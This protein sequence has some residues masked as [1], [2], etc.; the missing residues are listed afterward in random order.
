MQAYQQA[1]VELNVLVDSNQ[2]NKKM[3]LNEKPLMTDPYLMA[4]QSSLTTPYCRKKLDFGEEK[5]K[6]MKTPTASGYMDAHYDQSVAFGSKKSLP[7]CVS[8]SKRNARERKRVRTINDY[9]S[10][11]QKY[12]PYVKP[13]QSA[14]ATSNAC[15]NT[16]QSSVKST[17]A[18][19]KLSKVET[20]KAAIEYIELLLKFAPAGFQAKS[21]ASM[22]LNSSGSSSLLSSPASSNSSAVSPK[23]STNAVFPAQT[24]QPSASVASISAPI[25]KQTSQYDA[26]G[27]SSASFG[28]NSFTSANNTSSLK[29]TSAHYAQSGS[30]YVGYEASYAAHYA[31]FN[32]PVSSSSSSTSSLS[33]SVSSSSSSASNSPSCS[34]SYKDSYYYNN[35]NMAPTHQYMYNNAHFG[36]KS[37]DV[38]GMSESIAAPV[39]DYYNNGAAASN[40]S[41]YPSGQSV[42]AEY[43]DHQ[44][45]CAM[46]P[47]LEY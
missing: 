47:A 3:K 9:F 27:Y 24:E 8:N 13:N 25:S 12:L 38:Y 14:T 46:N 39:Y 7:K 36:G 32:S 16:S 26:S 28:G 20:L 19:K 17:N 4:T 1:K 30:G 42:K 22:S 6:K 11:L 10:Q 15:A 21:C 5:P 23:T 40:V 2:Q 45:A 29:D 43:Y 31:N 33:S 35:A 37:S 44:A 41:V 18:N 34:M